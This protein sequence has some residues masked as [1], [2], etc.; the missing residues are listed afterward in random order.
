MKI[1]IVL[2]GYDIYTIFRMYE[3]L[4]GVRYIHHIPYV[5]AFHMQVDIH[6][7]DKRN[8]EVERGEYTGKTAV[9][10]L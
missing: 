3:H 1:V 7:G 10:L 4:R 6:R 5:C 2:E 9:I 8:F